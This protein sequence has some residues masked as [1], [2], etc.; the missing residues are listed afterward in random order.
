MRQRNV[1]YERGLPRPAL[2]GLPEH[3]RGVDHRRGFWGKIITAD[4]AC[5]ERSLQAA[6]R[7]HTFTPVHRNFRKVNNL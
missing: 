1:H 5:Q 7:S 4:Q 2:E 3:R 6:D